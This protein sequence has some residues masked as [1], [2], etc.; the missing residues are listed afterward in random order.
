MFFRARCYLGKMAELLVLA[1]EFSASFPSL[2]C[3][4]CHHLNKMTSFSDPLYVDPERMD[5]I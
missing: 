5:N 3:A 1:L 4:S 2:L